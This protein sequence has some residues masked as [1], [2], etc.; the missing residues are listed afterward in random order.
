ML[1]FTLEDARLFLISLS[2]KLPGDHRFTF[3]TF[4]EGLKKGNKKLAKKLTGTFDEVYEE[5]MRL[6][7]KGA[8]I[9]VTINGTD[10]KGRKI[11]N[12][13]HLRA[14]FV[15]DDDG[16]LEESFSS[17]PNVDDCPANIIVRS[18]AGLHAYWLIDPR[19]DKPRFSEVQ[20]ALSKKYSTD[21]TVKDLSRVMRVPGF[22][23]MKNAGFFYA[24][25]KPMGS[26]WGRP[27][28]KGK[29]KEEAEEICNAWIAEQDGPTGSPDGKG[30]DCKIEEG[31]PFMVTLEHTD[32]FCNVTGRDPDRKLRDGESC[33]YRFDRLLELLDVEIIDITPKH[34]KP[35]GDGS[36]PRPASALAAEHGEYPHEFRLYLAENYLFRISP[37]TKF[38]NNAHDTVGSAC[39]SGHDFDC[40]PE[41]F[42]PILMRWG[43][44]C[45]P[46]F[47]DQDLRYEYETFLKAAKYAA[48][49]KLYDGDYNR[50]AQ[51]RKWMHAQ[52]DDSWNVDVIRG[53][54]V[55]WDDSQPG[56]F[57]TKFFRSDEPP[58]FEDAVMAPF[59]EE[60]PPEATPLLEPLAPTD[61]R[62]LT[63]EKA[64]IE[65]AI[66]K[67]QIDKKK[68]AEKRKEKATEGPGYLVWSDHGDPP[69][70]KSTKDGRF[71]MRPYHPRETAWHF[72]HSE[73][74]DVDGVR[75]LHYHMD[76]FAEWDGVCY[77][78]FKSD[79]YRKKPA[80]FLALCSEET[81]KVDEHDNPIFSQFKV[82]KTR[83][84]ELIEALQDL[85]SLD[86]DEVQS[87]CWLI[88]DEDLPDPREVI[89]C[90]NGLL[91]VRSNKMYPP[92]PAFFS[93][94]SISIS[95]DPEAE[96]PKEFLN[97][98]DDVFKSD[99]ESK[100][101]LKWWFGYCLT[102][103]T[104]HQKMLMLVGESR[105]GKGV[106]TRLL[107]ELVGQRAYGSMKFHRM[108][109]NFAL[110]S[111]LDKTVLVFPDA[112]IGSK[113]DQ[114]AVV[115][116]LLSITGEDPMMV[117][118]KNLDPITISLKCRIMI[119]SNEPLRLHD[120]SGALRNRVLLINFSEQKKEDEI[121]RGLEG[122]IHKE[123]P[124][125]LNWAIEGWHELE[126]RGRFFQPE[127][128]LPQL[129]A[130]SAQSSPMKQ[131]FE[132]IC[133]VGDD[134]EVPTKSLFEMWKIWAEIQG[135]RPGN[136]A[137]F[138]KNLI[139]VIPK[140][141]KKKVGPRGD[142]RQVYAGIAMNLDKLE[143]FISNNSNFDM[144]SI[145]E[146][147]SPSE[148]QKLPRL[149]N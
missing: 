16:T 50:R 71:K 14:A 46:P 145:R 59:P 76:K 103:D 44:M 102:Q 85:V 119:V 109:S 122:R 54:D 60:L 91:D 65:R 81:D 31:E 141:K 106:I 36:I 39:R 20:F 58:K 116:D 80:Q 92:N 128:G 125:I 110:S 21:D 133:D 37:P 113:L 126:A 108:A 28:G 140:L 135:Y 4:G 1:S 68:R 26:E 24:F 118:R 129:E 12:I 132:N 147:I 121:D 138:G 66:N 25:V 114:S 131:F 95:Y 82:T 22:S 2:C 51:Y 143:D 124:G 101:L 139:S 40:D 115:A 49:T 3:Q 148:Q 77:K 149:M 35:S 90:K 142:Q 144:I 104:R 70:L 43:G 33:G 17:D 64:R 83:K 73:C 105:S 27:V 88:D 9:F 94:N 86:G 130:F 57:S 67:T 42:W 13:T 146:R 99:E 18:R 137:T 61:E 48:G 5:L 53:D 97:F 41:A 56:G 30:W 93:L 112:R 111:A 117:D 62:L 134:K 8:G 32:T 23:N 29:T 74:R 47:D 96:K 45:S 84:S 15:D 6:N 63:D 69:E 75:T 55:P 11:E 19:E 10:G 100:M 52:G 79:G 78:R 107:K 136:Q 87:P 127:S 72:L 38:E 89:C 98:L 123:L 120:T 34:L 7:Q